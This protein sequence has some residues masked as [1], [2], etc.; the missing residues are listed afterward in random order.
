MEGEKVMSTLHNVANELDSQLKSMILDVANNNPAPRLATITKVS[1]DKNYVNVEISGG[2]LRGVEAFGYPIE[3]T[4][5]IIVF[6]DGRTAY[7]MAICNPMNM[8]SYSDPTPN[9]NVLTNG[10]FADDLEGWTGGTISTENA[11]YGFQSVEITS[12]NPLRSEPIDITS[13]TD[14]IVMV[15]F[16]TTG[17]ITTLKVYDSDTNEAIYY[18]P[19]SL[20]ET[21]ISSQG[22]VE[23]WDFQRF[24]F[25]KA[26]HE[27]ITLEFTVTMNRA[28]IDG[29][30][31]WNQD[32]YTDWYPSKE[33]SNGTS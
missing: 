13:L 7:P 29:V 17:E 12:S 4:R 28:F 33:D 15:C 22:N 18:V 24:P 6:I 16:W 9:Y 10:H 14:D 5:C 27:H 20:E 11:R 30:R 1:D 2:T 23:D 26:D 19:E 25:K 8:A 21:E 31:V 3:N 32:L